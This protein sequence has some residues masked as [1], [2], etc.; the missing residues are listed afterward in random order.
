MGNVA[1]ELERIDFSDGTTE[2]VHLVGEDALLTYRLWTEEET[3]LRFKG[4]V[5][6]R[7]FYL[8]GEIEEVRVRYKSTRL[9]KPSPPSSGTAGGLEG[10]QTTLSAT[11]T[12]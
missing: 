3:V 10:I 7:S 11:W 2:R 4:V 6:F 1:D 8:G 12:F 5:Y 9:T